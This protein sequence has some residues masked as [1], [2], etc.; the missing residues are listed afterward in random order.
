MP[1]VIIDIDN[2][3]TGFLVFAASTI[4]Y[5]V[6]VLIIGHFAEK[7]AERREVD[8]LCLDAVRES[9]KLYNRI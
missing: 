3:V 8:T 2:F 5:S 6:A 1:D 9:L 4:S 7:R